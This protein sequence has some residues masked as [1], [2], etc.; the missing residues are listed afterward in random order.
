[1]D[2]PDIPSG[3]GLRLYDGHAK[4]EPDS[5]KS[6]QLFILEGMPVQPTLFPSVFCFKVYKQK[7]QTLKACGAL[8]LDS[9][10]CVLR[11]GDDSY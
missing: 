7:L 10:G 6:G 2:S 8:D 1:M 4:T 11:S 5:R 9:G 3:L